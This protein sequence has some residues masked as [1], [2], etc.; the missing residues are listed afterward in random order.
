MDSFVTMSP[1]RAFSSESSVGAAGDTFS[2]ATS[3]SS[4]PPTTI[5][6]TISLASETSKMDV[7]TSI[8][9]SDDPADQ[10]DV[11]A[12]SEVA[13]SIVASAELPSLIQLPDLSDSTAQTAID[14][15]T[16]V[17]SR[18]ERQ[19]APIYN[20]AELAGTAIHGK[21]RSKGDDV[22]DRKRRNTVTGGTP[23][24]GEGESHGVAKSPKSAKTSKSTEAGRSRRI[25]TR[26]SGI[27][28]ETLAGKLSTL[29]KRGRKT[30]ERGISKMSR[31]LRRLQ[32][33]DEFAGIDKKPVLYTTWA[34]G[35]YVNESQ[36]PKKK[37]KVAD[38]TPAVPTPEPEPA[39]EEDLV[40]RKRR[41]KKYLDRGLYAGQDTPVDIYQSLTPS[42]KKSLA[43]LPE[44]MPSGGVNKVMPMPMYNG[45][46][47]LIHGRDF[48][49]PFDICHPLP[50]GQPKPDE[51]RKITKNRFV[52][53]AGAYWKKTPHFK[54]NTSKCVCKPQEGC[55]ESC[56]NRIMLYECDETNCNAGPEFCQNRPFAQ[57][58][59]RTKE[60]RKYHIG[61]EV[62]KTED[63]GYGIRA[64]RCFEPNQ[65]IMEYTGEI[66]TEEECDRRMNEVYKHNQCY[67][68]MSFDQNM[69]IDA[70]TGSIARFVNH[71]C[72]PNCKMVKWIVSGQPR[73]ALFAGDRPIMTGEELTYDYNFDPFSAKNVQKCLCGSTNCRGVLGPKPK[74]QKQPKAAKGS[75]T[76][77][78]K[79]GV[80][81]SKRKFKDVL[82][83][84][85]DDEGNAAKKRK[86][87]I[88][89]GPKTHGARGSFSTAG[90]KAAKGA[91][92]A[93]KRS[94]SSISG[95]AKSAL[96]SK[97][98]TGSKTTSARKSKAV[99]RTY[100]KTKA[101]S[102][103][104]ARLRTSPRIPHSP[105][106]GSTIIAAGFE[107]ATTSVSAS[108]K[109]ITSFE[110]D[111]AD[112][113]DEKDHHGLVSSKRIVE[114][115]R[116][117]SK[118]RIVES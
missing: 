69:I 88:P 107:K 110:Y 57:L 13:D 39:V 36:P 115:S 93:F 58:Q 62:L 31:E 75:L 70:T 91:A 12:P 61:V 73:M 27:E 63:R 33:T 97:S 34:N 105:N 96:S 72:D 66:I 1:T 23:I 5:A 117:E 37:A 98:A 68:L 65:I 17:R 35:K 76:E 64:N 24:D 82:G 109:T 49:L 16:N 99:V 95:G 6:D 100:S 3:L 38:E 46:R 87:K 15:P 52:G 7:P 11:D 20:I 74:E 112:E 59:E 47:T 78:V 86:I 116:T 21:R 113:E 103:P 104:P 102:K 111:E 83:E 80:N 84:K 50:P 48:K 41:A 18:R 79:K 29:G 45:M 67:Y 42:E 54:D 118:I 77:T 25:S 4:T 56:Q 32:D 85:D 92:T 101:Q 10:I 114:V 71:S 43:Q 9:R 2:N 94:M 55:G 8:G 40:P 30:F 108:K 81:A 22:S 26:S 28:A 106:S 60:G 19:S 53:D 44:L 89:T 14:T 51:W 90:L